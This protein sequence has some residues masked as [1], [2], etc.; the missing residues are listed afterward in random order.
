[1]TIYIDV[2]IVINAYT[3]YFT[4]K[5]AALL[6]H[7]SYKISRL[8]FASVLGGF[9]SLTALIPLDG[10][11]GTLLR[12]F[13]TG[14]IAI[15]AFGFEGFKRLIL[16]SAVTAV[17]G[18]I[19]C[20]GV[21]LLR[22]CTGNSFFASVRGYV[23]LDV[24]IL[25]L[26]FSTTAVYIIISLFRR[27]LDKPL[28][29]NMVKLEIKHKDCTVILNAYADSGNN[30]CDFLTGLPVI[31]CNAEKLR[32]IVPEPEIKDEIPKGVRIIPF[33]SVGGSGIITAFKP[34]LIIFHKENGDKKAVSALVGTG[35]TALEKENFDAIFNPKLLI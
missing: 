24:S 28:E 19:I 3:T 8:I 7:T 9:I 22:E 15:A 35:K 12:I 11:T 2:L 31:V 29:S 32:G 23:Y 10:L 25:T 34:D 33:S 21:M 30:L 20:G 17:S 13:L 18:A 6:L 14:L 26:I 27:F 5:A 1:M 4:L 16:T